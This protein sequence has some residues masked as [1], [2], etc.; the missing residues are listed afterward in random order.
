MPRGIG[1]IKLCFIIIIMTEGKMEELYRIH[2][3]ARILDCS[4]KEVYR[5]IR[6][7]Q[8]KAMRFGPR[9]TRI[10]HSS[11]ERFIRNCMHP[12]QFSRGKKRPKTIKIEDAI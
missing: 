1:E 10:S 12:I 9:Q 8:L 2:R 11:I 6:S 3:V 7:G 4:T 5:L